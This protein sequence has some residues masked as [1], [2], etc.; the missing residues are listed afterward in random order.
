MEEAKPAI[1][2]G[3][4]VAAG[5]ADFDGVFAGFDM[6][7]VELLGPVGEGALVQIEG[8]LSRFAGLEEHLS[9]ALELMLRA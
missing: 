1:N 3:G 7:V 4:D 5:R 2:H 6:P 8:N 9:E